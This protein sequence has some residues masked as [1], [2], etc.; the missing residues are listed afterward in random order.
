MKIFLA[1]VRAGS[2][3]AA[4]RHLGINRT[5]VGR[6]IDFLEKK[7]GVELFH[8]RAASPYPTD[9]GIALLHTATKMEAAVLELETKLGD[10]SRPFPTIRIATS[11]GI[12][13]EFIPDFAEFQRLH[14][15]IPLEISSELDPID[16]VSHRRAD[17][18]IGLLRLPPKHLE[19]IE[20]GTAHQALYGAKQRASDRPLGWGHEVDLAIPAQWT[21]SNLSGPRAEA[22]GQPCFNNWHELK[23]AVLAGMGTAHLWTFAAKGDDRLQQLAATE[24][25]FSFPL[26]LLRRSTF[27]A[28]PSQIV[29]MEFLQSQLAARLSES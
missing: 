7:L 6:R 24:P 29:L 9:A 25:R 18:G 8:Y 2:Y 10:K 20:I 26:W 1:A 13:S 27:P 21:S 5:T 19:G 4:A 14:P 11:A 3:T 28:S 12:G 22:A 15:K 17:L 23:Q 16:A